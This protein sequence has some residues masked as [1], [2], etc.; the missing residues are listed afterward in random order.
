MAAKRT[1]EE[2]LAL[3]KA[4]AK[5]VAVKAM[6]PAKAKQL[7]LELWPEAVRGVPNAA[8]GM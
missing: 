8:C 5:A 7:S 2:N 1:F 3:V 4:K 6:P